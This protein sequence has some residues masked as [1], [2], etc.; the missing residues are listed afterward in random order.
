[1]ST[2]SVTRSGEV[3]S[4]AKTSSMEEQ[5]A[6]I[7]QVMLED[8]K[9]R[10]AKAVEEQKRQEQNME[11]LI[12][13]IGE[14]RRTA[15]TE[16]IRGNV[17]NTVKLNKLTVEDGIE[18][19]LTTF[20]W[21][22]EGYGV[23]RAR[24]SYRLASNLTGK[25]QQAFVALPATEVGDYNQFK[26]AILK[27]YDVNQETYRQRF[28]SAK[29][30]TDESYS[31]LAVCLTDLAT[32]WTKDCR[33][34]ED[35]RQQ[36]VLGQFLNSLPLDTHLWVKEREPKMVRAAVELADQLT[37]ARSS[38]QREQR[39]DLDLTR[40]YWQVP[41]ALPVQPLTAFITP[42]GLFQFRVM[43]FGLNG[44]PALSS[45]LWIDFSV[46]WRTF[47]QLTWMT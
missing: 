6:Q 5:M 11:Q 26:A 21:M 44:A 8:R 34:V 42:S 9:K 41:V 47:Q 43:P 39:D 32:K 16:T 12:A 2:A 29:R 37:K 7:L 15:T 3:Y 1:M 18:A 14:T 17:K 45:D 40:G 35:I 4:K 13:L 25:V 30:V 22:M 24:W 36:L 38:D 28:C 46:A 31:E 20:E 27:R 33:S 10:D 23:N 19:Y